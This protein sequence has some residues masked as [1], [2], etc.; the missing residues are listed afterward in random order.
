MGGCDV[1]FDSGSSSADSVL[2]GDV[3]EISSGADVDG[4]DVEL[5]DESSNYWCGDMTNRRGAFKITGGFCGTGL[6][7]L[8]DSEGEQ[9]AV[10]SLN[11]FPSSDTDV[12]NLTVSSGTVTFDDDLITESYA[13]V[14]ENDCDAINT[15]VDPDLQLYGLRKRCRRLLYRGDELRAH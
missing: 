15:G 6:V 7:T 10:F 14:T 9:L 3:Y 2:S 5:E 8:T 1:E 4:I 13:Y 11:I 12:G